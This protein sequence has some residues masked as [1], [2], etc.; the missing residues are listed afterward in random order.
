M[1]SDFYYSPVGQSLGS[2]KIDV[3]TEVLEKSPASLKS[4]AKTGFSSVYRTPPD[5][6]VD[7]LAMDSVVDLRAAISDEIDM[8]V[9]VSSYSSNSPSWIYKIGSQLG[10]KSEARMIHIQDACTGFISSM[11]IAKDAIESGTAKNVLVIL[12]DTYSHY[13]HENPVLNMLFS[14]AASAII[15]SKDALPTQFSPKSHAWKV[16]S[17]VRSSNY[18]TQNS[19][20]IED[21]NLAMNGAAVYQFARKKI[22]FLV[23]RSLKDSNASKVD[24]WFVH[25]GSLAIVEAAATVLGL[26]L[27]E[28][29]RA[30]DYGNVVG[31]SIPF[32]LFTQERASHSTLGILAFGMGLTSSCM[33]IE[34]QITG[35]S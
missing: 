7:H 12:S 5:F 13:I 25:Q 8:V 35:S 27:D 15:F 2:Q 10:L 11:E 3:E 22:Q 31:S 29:F 30:S 1:C 23:E 33:I 20:Y 4:L 26:D 21:G 32:Q 9:G 34:E 18:G 19:L 28:L 16:L 14:D 17:S 6:G 24:Y